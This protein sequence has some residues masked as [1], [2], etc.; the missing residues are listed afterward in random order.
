MIFHLLLLIFSL[1][2]LILA[3][4]LPE[5]ATKACTLSPDTSGGDDSPAIMAAFDRCSQDSTIV[6][7]NGTYH[8]ERIMITT[9][10]KNVKVDMRGYLLW[11]TDLDYWRENG[12]PLGYLNMTTAWRF[13]GSDIL[14]EGHN[15]GTFDGNGQL[16]Y[17]LTKGVSN[18]PGRPI[19]LV[20][21]NT[22]DSVFDG[23]RF[24]Q[25]QFWT[26]A[27]TYSMGLLL[28]NIYINSTSM[29]HDPARNTDGVDTFYS[30]DL[31]FRN[32]TVNN[33]DDFIAPKAN[34][35]NILIQDSRFY[36]G[37]GVA[38]GSIGQYPG[39]YEF[40]ENVFAE[41]ITCI[42]CQYAA[43]VKTWT[44]V[45]QGYPPNG[46]GGGIGYARNI[47][48]RDFQVQNLTRA[49]AYI[50]QCTSFDG[51]TDGCDTSLFQLS[52]MAWE[53]IRGTIDTNVLAEL[54]CSGSAPCPGIS[55]LGFD[56]LQANGSE[57]EIQCSNI[58]NPVGF[59]CTNG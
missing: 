45:Q 44:G 35:S 56:M 29:N 36:H 17:D 24:V 54:Q 13:G 26:M 14:W 28:Q 42:E 7:E 11:S 12:I 18:L 21:T 41:R 5:R 1:H 58:V 46:G 55:L 50:T 23:I 31:V 22:S 2:G 59:Q 19:S 52:D 48:F 49:A 53:N 4:F 8:I 39:V 37:V 6:F 34:S 15:I 40:I 47:T 38:I 43:Y 57:R 51:A 32:W 25:S 20:I 33:D 27:I 3:R 16:W 10:L 9:G 30:D